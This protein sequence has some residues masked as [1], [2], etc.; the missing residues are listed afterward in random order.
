MNETID[1]IFAVIDYYYG[2]VIIVL[3][4]IISKLRVIMLHGLWWLINV[5]LLVGK[6]THSF[7]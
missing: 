4:P 3:I 6:E 7:H 5:Q 2:I 1:R